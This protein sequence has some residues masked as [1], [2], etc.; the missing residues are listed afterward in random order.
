MNQN[1]KIINLIQNVA[2]PHNNALIGRFKNDKRTKLILWYERCHDAQKYHW[3]KDL[4][5]EHFQANVY[6]S[7]INWKFLRYCLLNKNHTYFIVGWSNAN[8]RLLHLLFFVF[9][10]PFNH[11]TDLPRSLDSSDSLI[12]K[13]KRKLSYLI[14]R[15]SVAKVFCVGKL[16][17]NFF[18][19]EGFSASQLVNLPIFVETNILPQS[20]H[21]QRNTIFSKYGINENS[22]VLSSGSRIVYEK[23][24]DL[25]LRGLSSLSFG[26]RK[27]IKL[28]IVGC[29]EQLSSIMK[30]ASELMLNEQVIFVKWLEIEDFM[31]LIANSDVFIHPARVDAYGGTILG[32]ALGVPVIG[33]TGAGAAVDRIDHGLNGFLYEVEDTLALANYIEQLYRNPRLRSDMAIQARKTALSWPP[34]AGV[35]IILQN[36]I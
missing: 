4:T 9:R 10:R 31:S 15:Y 27:N 22:F 16:T 23:G 33:S 2:T 7:K 25:L 36:A 26:I 35:E 29:G 11:W 24:Y 19:K 14:L 32:M 1:V 21:S 30:L 12:R 20:F 8:T 17:I 34:E 13:I 5:N 3:K 18:K 28:F 6:G